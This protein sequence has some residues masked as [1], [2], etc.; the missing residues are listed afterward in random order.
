[1]KGVLLIMSMS[2]EKMLK[3]LLIVIALAFT[4]VLVYSPHFNYRYPLHVDE[5]QHIAK[6]EHLIKYKE[7]FDFNPYLSTLVYTPNMERGMTVF[8]AE[9][10]LL[11]D[12]D[13]AH[14]YRFLPA[15]FAAISAFMLFSLVFSLTEEFYAAL[16]SI[17]FF[18]ALKSNIN[19]LGLWFFTPLTF[20]IPFIYLSVLLFLKGLEE[21]DDLKIVM[22]FLLL[23]AVSLIQPLFTIFI[24][25]IYSIFLLMNAGLIKKNI[26]VLSILIMIP[27]LLLAYFFNFFWRGDLSATMAYMST[28]MIFSEGWGRIELAYFLPSLYGIVPVLLAIAGIYPAMKRRGT[29][30]FIIWAIVSLASIYIFRAYSFS[31][32][33]PYQR[34][35][36]FCM[37]GM[38]PL[39]AM[40]L[41]WMVKLIKENFYRLFQKLFRSKHRL[42]ARR[43]GIAAAF[44]FFMIVAAATFHDYY[45]PPEE[46]RIY[47]VIEEKDYE[48]LIFLEKLE[49][50]YLMAP[51][52]MSSAVYPISKNF[53]IGVTEG[54]LLPGNMS[55]VMDFYGGD[56]SKKRDI[57]DRQGI[58]LVLSDREI[59]CDYF[60]GRE[61]YSEGHHIYC[62]YPPELLH[63]CGLGTIK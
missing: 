27:A 60:K 40:G 38:A 35:I 48:T 9:F 13:P 19:I 20:S 24:F 55:E 41:D 18:A 50:S 22:S 10:F 7:I 47:H 3:A 4:F 62:F 53:V 6:A 58:D 39:S 28:F 63:E 59:E 32:L 2:K 16:F 51:L 29:R 33:A 26:K 52:K 43:S 23:I 46:D 8:L 57:M 17:L 56:C 34:M 45:S 12:L 25:M 31:L 5:W 1:M 44:V 21:K 61:I 30:I 54:N 11:T 14:Y 37:L 15:L 49:G 36:Y 42:F